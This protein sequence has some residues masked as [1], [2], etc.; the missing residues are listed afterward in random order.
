MIEFAEEDQLIPQWAIVIIVIGVG[1]LIFV[2]I[3]GVTVVR[4]FM[5]VVVLVGSSDIFFTPIAT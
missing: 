2:I 3:F 5:W 1:S 4:I